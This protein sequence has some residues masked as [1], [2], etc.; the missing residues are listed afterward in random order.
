[1]SCLKNYRDGPSISSESIGVYLAIMSKIFIPIIWN[2][3]V[4]LWVNISRTSPVLQNNALEKDLAYIDISE[5]LRGY[6]KL[7]QEARDSGE[8]KRYLLA[9]VANKDIRLTSVQFQED[10]L[11]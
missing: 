5:D 3:L 6:W 9:G 4:N 8:N 7:S 2:V 10:Y 11:F 1:M